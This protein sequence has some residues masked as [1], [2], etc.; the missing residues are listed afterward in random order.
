MF[1]LKTEVAVGIMVVTGFALLT[2]V[3]FGVSGIYVFRPGYQ[4]H[5]IFNFVS[6]IDQGAPVRYAGVKVG[7]VRKVEIMDRSVSQPGYIRVT[8][9]VT[10]GVNIYEGDKI[11]IQGTHI[12]SEPHIAIEPVKEPG[13]LLANGD[14]V[15]GL[16]PISMDDLIH[17]AK[18]ITTM[19]N[20]FLSETEK[21][22][23]ESGAQRALSDSLVNLSKL[24]ESLNKIVAGREEDYRSGLTSLSKSLDQV[25]ALLEKVS[26]GEGTMGKLMVNDE[27]YN[28]IREFVD[29]LKRP[30]W[31]LLKKS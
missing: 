17:N 14:T 31:R 13:R 18:E 5:A 24:L 12:M 11:S 29:E 23:R 4:I 8:F 2:F 10:K 6:I 16:D 27:L 26:R 3:V 15:K 28:Q 30:P 20:Q 21:T 1:K 9:F 7:E 25:N 19:L 22:L